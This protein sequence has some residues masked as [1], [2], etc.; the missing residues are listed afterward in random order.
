[1]RQT[2]KLLVLFVT[3]CI[4]VVKQG[5]KKPRTIRTLTGIGIGRNGKD[6]QNLN[7][8]HFLDSTLLHMQISNDELNANSLG[9]GS[10]TLR[11]ISALCYKFHRQ[12]EIL[13]Y[14]SLTGFDLDSAVNNRVLKN[15]KISKPNPSRTRII[16]RCMII[17]SRS[18]VIADAATALH[19]D[20]ATNKVHICIV[21]ETWLK[22]DV[23]SH[24]VCPLGYT[25]ARK[26]RLP[27]RSGGGVAILCRNDWKVKITDSRNPFEC[28][29]CTIETPNSL[30]L[31]VGSIQSS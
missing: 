2:S 4:V 14:A 11:S 1:M 19:T 5:E 27:P 26:D 8:G 3:S 22:K 20:L 6:H 29:W 21:S 16:P 31:Y 30:F 13:H 17:N 18:L 7:L 10:K 28:L 24:L 23:P 9:E 15:V 25:I 12:L